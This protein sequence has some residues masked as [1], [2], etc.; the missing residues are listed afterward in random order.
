[1]VG[2]CDIIK[3]DWRTG[4]LVTQTDSQCPLVRIRHQWWDTLSYGAA[5]PVRHC[6]Q[7]SSVLLWPSALHRPLTRPL[8][9][10]T[11]RHFGSSW[12]LETE[13]WW[14]QTILAE[15]GGGWPATNEPRTGDVE[16]ACSGQIGM[17]ETRGNGYVYNKLLKKKKD[18]RQMTPRA[19]YP[20]RRNDFQVLCLFQ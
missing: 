17:A 20:H 4:Q 8:P 10:S 3:E 5:T 12:W 14:S 9:C 19:N 6:S 16:A 11:A 15:N 1:M 18:G 7:S 13:D 2:D